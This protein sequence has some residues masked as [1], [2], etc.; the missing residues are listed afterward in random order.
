M[1]NPSKTLRERYL[2][3][4]RGEREHYL[5]RAKEASK[6]TLPSLIRENWE[7]ATEDLYTPYQSVGGRGVQNL[8]AKMLLALFPPTTSFFRLL[9]S[10]QALEEIP[11]EQRDVIRSEVEDSLREYE[12]AVFEELEDSPF[13]AAVTETLKH[14]LITGNA[15]FFVG[16][17][18][19]FRNYSI[20]DYVVARDVDGN[21]LELIVRETVDKKVIEEYTVDE[22]KPELPSQQTGLPSDGNA[23]HVH[24]FT[25]CRRVE[26]DTFLITQEIKDKIVFEQ[27]LPEEEVPY[28]V[29][30]LTEA[31]GEAY[32]RSYV[33]HLIGDLQSL[34]SLSQSIV[35]TAAM[36]SKTVYFVNPGSMVRPKALAEAE[37]GAVLAGLATDVS[38]LQNQK[39]ADLNIVNSIVQELNQRLGLAFLL[40]ENA[41]RDSERTTAFEVQALVNSLEQVL[42][43]VYAVL[44]QTFVRPFLRQ[45]IKR[46]IAEQKLQELPESVKLIVST[47]LTNLGRIS[48]LEKLQQFQQTVIQAV[49][50]ELAMQFIDPAELVNR[51]ANSIGVEKKGLVKTKRQIQEEQEAA[52]AQQEMMQAQQ[53]QQQ[54]LVN[55]G[56]EMIK[57][58]TDPEK[59]AMMQEQL[60]AMQEEIQP[61]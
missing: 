46:L 60:A 53:M 21:L 41:V 49:G 42:A 7:N 30:R 10:E 43:G 3:L 36:A 48:E 9:V 5:D 14:L 17:N 29:V 54:L 23:N 12:Q 35:Q 57:A 55:A 40:F 34:E 44:N 38:V 2:D 16:S 19:R 61:E 50:P 56:N 8:S 52:Q 33:E 24:L 11:E 47:G 4:A 27:E 51:I 25:S 28:L 31:T 15:V 32:G 26:G 20:E 1:I 18:Q 22:S 58:S 45:T 59:S 6:L 37:N 13:R 39:G